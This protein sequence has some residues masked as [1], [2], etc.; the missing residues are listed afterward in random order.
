MG[1][2][3]LIFYA[4]L[5]LWFPDVKTNPVPAVCGILFSNVRGQSKNLSDL[6]VASSVSYTVV[7][8]DF[9]LT[10]H[11]TSELL[12]PVF[13]RPD[14]LCQSIMPRARELTAFVSDGYWA[15]R[16]PKFQCGCCEILIFRVCGTR[17]NFFSLPLPWPVERIYDC[18]LTSMAD[19]QAENVCA[20]FM[21]VGDLNGHH[22]E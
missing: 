16:Q 3:Y 15:F 7:L 8:W 12:V 22:Q 1:S 17:R 21:F 11:H 10:M 9:G 19:L 18:L 20:S 4:C 5:S 2:N 13:D 6:T 14:V